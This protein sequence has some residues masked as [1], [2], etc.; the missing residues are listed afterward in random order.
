MVKFVGVT[1][2]DIAKIANVSHTTVSRALNNSSFIK[3]D[4]RRRILSIAEELNYVPNYNAKSLVMKKSYTIGLFFTTISDGTSSSFFKEV[5]NGV[6][7]SLDE[8]YSL[9]IRGLDTY[10]DF[11]TINPAKFDGIILMSQG[12]ID[13]AFIDHVIEKKIPIVVLNREIDNPHIINILSADRKGVEAAVTYLI[14]SGH[15]D[16]ACIEGREGFKSTDERRLG[17]LDALEH[18]HLEVRKEFIVPGK[19]TMKS[20]YKA[21]QELLQL[22]TKPTAVFCS[23]DD[24]AIGAMN[25]IA[26]AGLKIPEDISIVGFDSIGYSEYTT[27]RL[28]SVKRMIEDISRLSAQKLLAIVNKEISD[29]EQIFIE[30]ILMKRNSV[31]VREKK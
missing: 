15:T 14:E 11:S 19:Y 5:I 2:K 13:D 1:I 29:G 20:G 12:N 21:M 17:Y 31:Q 28:T 18:N 23:N 16:I 7:E 8:N 26:E 30:T 27:P 24:M 3:L 22:P 25:A 4:T 10:K 6:V 9:F